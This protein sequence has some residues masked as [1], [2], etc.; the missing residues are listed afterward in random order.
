MIGPLDYSLCDRTV[1]VYRRK[2][3]EILR[4][5][6]DGCYYTWQE[7][8][9]VDKAG[10]RRETK[11]LLIIPGDKQQLLVGDRV[12]DGV[13]PDVSLQNWAAFIPVKVAG[14]AQIS[15]V[16]PY[17]WEGALCHVEAGRK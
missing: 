7:V 4:Q 6:I 17:Y 11:C 14:L 13:G 10:C 12:L 5:V 16:Q 3:D 9:V 15:Y 1:T 2:E 8:Q